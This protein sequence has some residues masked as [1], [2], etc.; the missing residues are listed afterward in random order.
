MPVPVA[1]D[2]DRAM[3]TTS[4]R[5]PPGG[6]APAPPT[7]NGFF[8]A[9]RRIGVARTDD[10]W[11]GGVCAGL[12]H[13]FGLDPLLVRALVAVSVL[14]GGFGLVLYGL[15]WALLPEARDGRIHLEETLAGR[16]DVALL[17]AVGLV[18]VGIGRGGTWI[19][20]WH[21]PGAVQGL[22]WLVLIGLAVA[23]VV[24]AVQRSS[25]TNR[26]PTRYGPFRAGEPTGPSAPSGPYGPFTAPSPAAT[27]SGWSSTAAAPPPPGTGAP[28]TTSQ[29]TVVP[30]APTPQSPE[31]GDDTSTP[32]APGTDDTLVTPPPVWTAEQPTAA[33]GPAPTGAG[34]TATGPTGWQ[35]PPARAPRRLG[36]GRPTTGVVVALSLLTL[37]GLLLADR[38]GDLVGP[39]GLLAAGA[40]VVWAGLGI[41]VA[42]LRG[43]RGG[44]LSTLAVIV[45]LVAW[46][47]STSSHWWSTGYRSG[48]QT[49]HVTDVD[50]AQKG[51][52]LGYG[53]TVVDL[54]DLDLHG[55]TIA[56]PVD[57]GAGDLTIVLPADAGLD[58]SLS[59]GA[60][61]LRWDVA[62]QG[63]NA[64]GV[65][66]SR[67]VTVTGTD[68]TLRLDVSVGAGNLTLEQE[69]GR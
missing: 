58:G 2:D 28:H 57:Q 4:D 11:I 3:D 53:K 23:L 66:L 19:T 54:S 13:R 40:A 60:G 46:P 24:S 9:M 6:P 64:S 43:R 52:H 68:G 14:L 15:G 39:V 12:A 35:P 49:V 7:Q 27:S 20:P 22:G 18:F 30:D 42:G 56:V 36:P 61:S 25:G 41:I 59:V 44:V 55:R 65:G 33:W 10:R 47:F 63:G 37:A 1:T 50:A 21:V 69:A 67:T 32:A 38:T 17:G 45:L 48:D 29:E 26:P 34:P 31:T 62:D 51:V 5:T 16:F 8:G